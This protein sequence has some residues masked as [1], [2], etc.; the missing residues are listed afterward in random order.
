M[1]TAI[2]KVHC[3]VKQLVFFNMQKNVVILLAEKLSVSQSVKLNA[4]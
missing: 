4:F 2:E 3:T 1:W